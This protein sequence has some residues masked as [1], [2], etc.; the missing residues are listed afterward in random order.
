MR[1]A[2]WQ[3]GQAH[4]RE[5]SQV[6]SHA[7]VGR[8]GRPDRRLVTWARIITDFVF[9]N[10]N[11]AHEKTT[12]ETIR[13]GA[14]MSIDGLVQADVIILSWNRVED[15]IAAAKSAIEQE[16]VVKRIQIVDQGS[17]PANL[18]A[19][20]RFVAKAEDIRL[21]RLGRNTGVAG[22]RNIATAMGRAP[23][24]IALDSDA[25]FADRHT[26][27]RAVAHLDADPGLCAIGFRIVNFFSGENDA[28]SWDYPAAH[29]PDQRFST[30]RFVGA[31]HAIRRSVF[32]A[33]GGYDDRLFFC[34]EELDLCY[35]MLN[36]GL[37][38]DYV[39]DVAVLHKVSP[40]HRSY[41]E[42]VDIFIQCETVC[43]VPT[44]QHAVA[45]PGDIGRCVLREGAS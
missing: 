3:G 24:I 29:R 37:R 21:E 19:L 7:A 2:G 26:V 22:G 13:E 14:A 10:G 15:T 35:R 45:A 25:I 34:G 9:D 12:F 30:T 17:D 11:I 1:P 18:A 36:A 28:G 5:L 27:S 38:I 16:G 32:T 39:P 8:R 33:V 40:D 44:I 23:Y 20:E 41:W 4:A 43:L 6:T 42:K 31:G